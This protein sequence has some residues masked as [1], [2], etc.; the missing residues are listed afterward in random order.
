MKIGVLGALALLLP[1][2]ADEGQALGR[3]ENTRVSL[4]LRDAPLGA[5]LEAL[6]DFFLP[7]GPR[8]HLKR[9]RRAR[10]SCIYLIG[11]R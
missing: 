5:A 11:Q 1:A 8:R 2:S 9:W 4:D 7:P 3:L 10:P 6:S